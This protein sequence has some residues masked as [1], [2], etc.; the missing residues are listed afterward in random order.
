[1]GKSNIRGSGDSIT[2]EFLDRNLQKREFPHFFVS[3]DNLF[4]IPRRGPG[5]RYPGQMSCQVPWFIDD[6][7]AGDINKP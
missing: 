5:W 2:Q 7:S 4:A 1:V 3:K 6:F